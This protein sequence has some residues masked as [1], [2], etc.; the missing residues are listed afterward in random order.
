MTPRAGRHD[1]C[2][3]EGRTKDLMALG[4][5]VPAPRRH[6]VQR[7]SAITEFASKSVAHPGRARVSVRPA[8]IDAEREHLTGRSQSRPAHAHS[9][10]RPIPVPGGESWPTEPADVLIIGAGCL[11]AGVVGLAQ[12]GSRSCASS[13]ATRFSSLQPPGQQARTGHQG[14]QDG[15]PAPTSAASPRTTR[16]SRTTRPVSPL[17]YTAVG[18]SML[19]F[20]GA[21]PRALPSD[22]RVRALDGIADD[23][24]IDYFELLP[25]FYGPIASS[26]SPAWAATRRTR[27]TR[28]PAAAAAADRRGGLRWLG[29][30]PSWAGTGGPSST[31]STRRRTTAGVPCV[32]RGTCQPG[33]NEGAK[34]STDLTHW[35]KAIATA[36]D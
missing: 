11:R 17:M 7:P 4:R 19:I 33:C 15:R 10:F 34:A 22:F 26:G 23:W 29:P 3:Q 30:T 1:P 12:A 8:T 9:N 20:A 36:R 6:R 13:R 35:P 18:G 27:P 31:R 32:Q 25:Y 28:G 16:S 2:L 21:W 14:A 5:H 24:P